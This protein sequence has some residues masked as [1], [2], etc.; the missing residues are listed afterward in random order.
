MI[1]LSLKL[2]QIGFVIVYKEYRK[3]KQARALCGVA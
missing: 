3:R 2:L 1:W